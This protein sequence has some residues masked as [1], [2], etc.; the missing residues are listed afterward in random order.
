MHTLEINI[1]NNAARQQDQ[2]Q[3]A[4]GSSIPFTYFLHAYSGYT[5]WFGKDLDLGY[6]EPSL[7]CGSCLQ[8]V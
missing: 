5:A 8:N 4:F 7:F 2:F 3:C 6:S 1:K